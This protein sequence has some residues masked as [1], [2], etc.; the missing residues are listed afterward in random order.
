MDNFLIQHVDE[1]TR[2]I[3]GQVSSLLDV[4]IPR[5]EEV[6]TNIEYSHVCSWQE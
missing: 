6:V 1:D 5:D 2:V 4:I 3:E